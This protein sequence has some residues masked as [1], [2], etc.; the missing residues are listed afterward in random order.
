MRH[1]LGPRGPRKTP[2]GPIESGSIIEQHRVGHEQGVPYITPP[3]KQLA[4]DRLP[5]SDGLRHRDLLVE[6]N[7][8]PLAQP[9]RRAG[10]AL[11]GHDY[12]T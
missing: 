7:L 9:G 3:E 10:E 11:V 4:N 5:V 1:L 8:V 12:N 6:E 2:E